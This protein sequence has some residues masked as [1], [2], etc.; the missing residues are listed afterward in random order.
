MTENPIYLS[1][2]LLK[3]LEDHNQKPKDYCPRQLYEYYVSK[4]FTRQRTISMTY[5]A[6]FETKVLGSGRK[7]DRV[8]DLP[9]LQSGGDSA[10]QKKIDYQVKKVLEIAESQGMSIIPGTNTQILIY[11]KIANNVYM[12]GHL[13]WFPVWTMFEDSE[14]ILSIVDLKLTG[15][16]DNTYGDY[17][18]G[19]PQYMDLVQGD[20]YFQLVRDIDF[21]LNDKLNPGNNL[22]EIFTKKVIDICN[23]GHHKFYFLVFGYNC[24]N[25]PELLDEQMEIIE[26]VVDNGVVLELKERIRRAINTLE[27]HEEFG[28]PVN[29]SRDICKK[30]TVSALN[31]GFCKDYHKLTKV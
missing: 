13:D 5:G 3:E 1:S 24:K 7:G 12:G 21:V 19:A 2:S 28:W 14:P 9:K 16:V 11:K 27:E 31:G 25:E 29:P 15:A 18:W 30:C 8:D 26:R 17:S 22:R 23:K 4:R 10:E 20:V 6:Y